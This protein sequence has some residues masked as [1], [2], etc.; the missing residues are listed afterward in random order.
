MNWA[1][2]NHDK[3]NKGGVSAQRLFRQ[4]FPMNQKADFDEDIQS[5]EQVQECIEQWKN[6]AARMNAKGKAKGK[7]FTR[8]AGW[9]AKGE[10]KAS[11]GSLEPSRMPPPPPPPPQR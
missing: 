4:Q 10:G 3:K 8:D 7:V 1:L 9:Q 6:L 11:S 5:D 2:F